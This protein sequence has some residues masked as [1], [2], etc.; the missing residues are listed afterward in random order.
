MHLHLVHSRVRPAS[1]TLSLRRLHSHAYNA[2]TL[3]LTYLKHPWI[4]D[5][6]TL[7]PTFDQLSCLA[8]CS[9]SCRHMPGTAGSNSTVTLYPCP[10][11]IFARDTGHSIPGRSWSFRD[12]WQ[13]YCRID[14]WVARWLSGR[15]SDLRS[16]VVAG[17]RPG[18]DAAA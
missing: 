15:A 3:T 10:W 2:L 1:V 16:I 12:G 8:N 6:P 7:V 18:R 9:L 4:S 13:A 14:D 5:V 17:S 11:S